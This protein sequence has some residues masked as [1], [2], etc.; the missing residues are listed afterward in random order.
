MH[1]TRYQTE[2]QTMMIERGNESA[3]REL[4]LYLRHP[5]ILI[6]WSLWVLNDHV[7]KE[8]FA[9]DITGKLS[10]V[11]S[12]AVFPL[13]PLACYELLCYRLNRK[14]RHQK[15]IFYISLL[16]TGMVMVGI[17]I[18]PMW[19]YVYRWGLGLFQW[20]FLAINDL[21]VLGELRSLRPV[22]LTMDISDIYTLPALVVPWLVVRHSLRS[23][24]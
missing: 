24:S 1:M 23:E 20:P 9:N 7:F 19:A 6:F 21:F 16:A 11:A 12:L 18:S 14:R 22:K 10:D 2:S 4:C 13:F 8:M 15:Q 5:V 3:V 17:N